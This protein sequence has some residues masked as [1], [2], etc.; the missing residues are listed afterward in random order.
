MISRAGY[1]HEIP[2][3]CLGTLKEASP[4]LIYTPMNDPITTCHECDLLQRLPPSSHEEVAI[5]CVRCGALLQ[6]R[7][8]RHIERPLALMCSVAVLF[9]IA[10]LFPIIG[11]DS[12]GM[13][14]SVSIVQAVRTL[15]D[16]DMKLVSGLV[17][18]TTLLAPGL[19]I[20]AL[21][22]I[23]GAIHFGWRFAGLRF[24]MRMAFYSRP[25]SMVE[26]FVLGILVSVV[27]LSHIAHIN[28]GIALWC[29]GALILLFTAAMAC[30][31]QK[32]LWGRLE[33]H[34]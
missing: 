12:T 15:W 13:H 14:R 11:I 10:N 32:S 27:K 19:E 18:T 26:V 1:P 30:L 16:D 22:I 25:W 3:R 2:W 7:D 24:L 5:Q 21:T 29:Y 20:F 34:S 6:R 23:L 4:L 33:I 31:D 28:T 9:L 17:L 8:S